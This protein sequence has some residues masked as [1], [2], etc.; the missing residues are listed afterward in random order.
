MDRLQDTQKRYDPHIE[1]IHNQFG[2]ELCVNVMCGWPQDCT[3]W[4]T[5][6]PCICSHGDTLSPILTH[7]CH[8]VMR[9]NVINGLCDKTNIILDTNITRMFLKDAEI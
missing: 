1:F 3:L 5:A 2:D 7:C 6:P 4:Y 8:P 9:S